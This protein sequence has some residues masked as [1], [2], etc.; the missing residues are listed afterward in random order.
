MHTALSAAVHATAAAGDEHVDA[1][2]FFLATYRC[3]PV[4]LSNL[5]VRLPRTTLATRTSLGWATRT[6]LGWAGRT[7]RATSIV[8]LTVVAPLPFNATYLRANTTSVP[9]LLGC[10][11]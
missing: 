6:S 1:D 7:I 2:L 9:T 3:R 11:L 4:F 8:A 5:C 10:Q